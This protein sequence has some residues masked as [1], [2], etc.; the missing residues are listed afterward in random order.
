[1]SYKKRKPTKGVQNAVV[2]KDAMIQIDADQKKVI[3]YGNVET[4]EITSET[5]S[6]KIDTYT[7]NLATYNKLLQKADSLVSVLNQQE[8]EIASDF[9]TI[10]T[11]GA[12]IFGANSNELVQLG[13]KKKKERSKSK[14][15]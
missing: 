6:N 15:K 8:E 9:A 1:M 13:G 7:S 5:F 12:S 2:R 11:G 14:K 3:N 4:G 10:L